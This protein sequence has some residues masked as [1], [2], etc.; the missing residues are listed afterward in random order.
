MKLKLNQ[1]C[2]FLLI[3]ISL[4]VLS[5]CSEMGN[6]SDDG[7][8][9][10]VVNL[11][12]DSEYTGPKIVY[13]DIEPAM[14]LEEGEDFYVFV[15][16]ENYGSQDLTQGDLSVA[17][18]YSDDLV[19]WHEQSHDGIKLLGYNEETYSVNGGEYEFS[20]TINFIPP[21]ASQLPVSLFTKANFH[22]NTELEQEVCIN[23]SS[24]GNVAGNC[25]NP[26]GEVRANPQYSPVVI[27]SFEQDVSGRLGRTDFVF[28]I[29]NKGEGK[30][31]EISLIKA[32]LT[33]EDM[34]CDFVGEG[35]MEG[36]SYVFEGSEQVVDLECEYRFDSNQAAMEKILYLDLSYNYVLSETV[37]LTI[38]KGR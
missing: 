15:L 33:A 25:E 2:L 20:G 22:Y 34:S 26:V 23:P 7:V 9:G 19:T 6:G 1:P 10:N 24:Y 13:V 35:D 29:E 30:I 21:E 14:G 4:V 27:T 36:S 16:L 5:S 31:E 32:Q 38:E 3:I 17:L 8:R 12:Y 28:R 37:E 18:A 11:D